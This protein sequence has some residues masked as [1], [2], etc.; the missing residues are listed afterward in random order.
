MK[1]FKFV[2]LLLILVASLGTSQADQARASKGICK[3]TVTKNSKVSTLV[4]AGQIGQLPSVQWGITQGCYKA[5]G[6]NVKT[7]PVATSQ[8][9][10]AGVL[11]GTYDLAITT[12]VNLIQAKVNG[13]V[14]GI[15]VAPRHE[16]TSAQLIRAQTQPLYPGHLILQTGLIVKTNSSIKSWSD[17]AGKKIAI[18]SFQS[19]D[20]AGTLLALKS[21]GADTANVQFL[22]M[23]STQMGAA[24][25]SGSVDAVVANEPFASQIIQSGGTLIG[26]PNSYFQKPGAAVIYASISSVVKKKI[27][28]MQAFQKATLL[29]NH[30]LNQPENIDSYRDTIATVTGITSDVAAATQLPVMMD[31]NI[32]LSDISY[33]ADEL[34]QVGFMEATPNLQ[35]MLF[36]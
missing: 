31:K 1:R 21:S 33:I 5:F 3:S 6:L 17:L 20:H 24:L 11:G 25:D 27:K 22:T 15:F 19:A 32:A 16:Y 12:P 9:A 30:Q 36:K 26:Y 18:Q 29:I 10:L 4:V 7:V 2:T 34:K 23:P 8:L 28:L 35:S 14:A 13:N